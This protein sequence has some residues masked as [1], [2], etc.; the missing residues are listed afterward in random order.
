[1]LPEPA[2]VTDKNRDPKR[3]AMRRA[4]LERGGMVVTF[5][6]EGMCVCLLLSLC[7]YAYLRL[8]L[9]VWVRTCFSPSLSVYVRM[10]ERLTQ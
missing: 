8:C 6:E 2:A 7:V 1:M 3:V 10:Y 4:V 9:G 5:A